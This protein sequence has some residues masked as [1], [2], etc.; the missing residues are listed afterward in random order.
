[1]ATKKWNNIPEFNIKH[2]ES[3]GCSWNYAKGEFLI[4]NTKELIVLC[5]GSL[6]DSDFFKGVVLF[7][8][9]DESFR[10]MTDEHNNVYPATA[11]KTDFIK[12]FT[13]ENN[14]VE[15]GDMSELFKKEEF[16]LFEGELTIRQQ[17]T[18]EYVAE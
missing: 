11:K 8:G 14:T 2:Y 12:S 6:D 3:D 16:S 10:E 18:L 13:H 17:E 1:M 15:S 5:L 9:E 7:N 4:S